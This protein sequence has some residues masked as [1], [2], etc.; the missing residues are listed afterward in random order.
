MEKHQTYV[1]EMEEA[2]AKVHLEEED[3]GGL[4]YENTPDELSEIDTRWCLVGRFLTESHID[5]Q[6]MQHKMASLWRPRRGL[7]VK[8]MDNNRF[9][10]Q[11]YHEMDIMRVI[12]GSPWTF[13]R[14]HLVMERL[15]SGDDPRTMEIGKI[16]LW[17]QL[18]GM[19]PGFMSQRVDG[20]PNN[21]M[22]EKPYGP[23]L[24]EDSRRKTHTMGAK[25]LQSGGNSQARNSGEMGS[26]NVD[27]R[28]SGKDGSLQQTSDTP[29]KSIISEELI[30]EVIQGSVG[31][32]QGIL[33]AS[34]S[35]QIRNQNS[36]LMLEGN[37]IGP[38]TNEISIMDPKRRR[39]DGP[40]ETN[41]NIIQAKDTH[42]EI[43]MILPTESKNESM[44]SAALQ[45]RQAL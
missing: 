4:S 23:W 26:V 39:G 43:Q 16:D 35:N 13:G 30:Q 20:D 18:H 17:V 41:E 1:K 44:A 27:K 2:F 12:E 22:I 40:Y 19:T 25:W 45:A 34:L 14:F 6:A 5:F 8:Q 37:N 31:E 33:S 36:I 21:F 9:L 24:R 11:V 42:M 10:F 32:N 29:G 3:Q 28:D 38:D 15:K 7:Y